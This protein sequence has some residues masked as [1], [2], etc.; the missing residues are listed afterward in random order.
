MKT[1]LLSHVRLFTTPWTVA[2]QASPSMGFS[3]QEY[4]SGL[5]F[6][7]PE[8]RINFS[9]L[10]FTL[11][12]LNTLPGG[13]GVKNPPA[14]AGDPGLIPGSERSPGEWNGNP[15]QYSCLENSWTEEPGR[16][17]LQGL[18]RV[19]HAWATNTFTFTDLS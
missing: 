14:N 18:Q 3:R 15:L 16:L 17:Q 1:K 5:W 8:I 4:W 13:S 12:Y 11:T 6:P 2:H 10:L 9:N 19:G 7:S